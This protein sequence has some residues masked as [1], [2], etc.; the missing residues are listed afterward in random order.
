MIAFFF[1]RILDD[2]EMYEKSKPFSL[3]NLVAISN[4]LNYFIF[5]TIWNNLI[6]K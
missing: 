2:I 6:G 3:E 5:R 1:Y 4:F